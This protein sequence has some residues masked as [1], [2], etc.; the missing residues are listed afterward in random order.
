MGPVPHMAMLGDIKTTVIA[1]WTFAM[2]VAGSREAAAGDEYCRAECG[3]AASA[4]AALV[5]ARQ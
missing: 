4:S 2:A 1:S 3:A 5:A